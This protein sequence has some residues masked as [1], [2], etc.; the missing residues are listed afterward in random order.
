MERIFA[1][2]DE[3]WE[4]LSKE[5]E[6]LEKKFLL[7]L[8]DFLAGKEKHPSYLITGVF[9][10][11]K[12]VFLY[13]LLKKCIEKG[14]LPIF[15]I[16]VDLFENIDVKNYGEVKEKINKVIECLKQCFKS[17][18]LS[19]YEKYI[20]SMPD[21]SKKKL[22]EYYNRNLDKIRYFDKVV[23]LIDELEDAYRILEKKAGA[24]PLRTWLEDRTYLKILALTPTGIYDLGGADESRLIKET[25][26]AVSIEYI[27]EKF[28][29]NAGKANALW[30]LSRGVPRHILQ[31][32]QKLRGV[33]LEFDPYRIKEILESLE[34]I[35]KRPS[36]VPAVQI[37]VLSDFSKIKNLIDIS[38]HDIDETYEGFIISRNLDEGALANVF[39]DVFSL[40]SEKE[41]EIALLMAHY[42]KI[43]AMTLS[44]EDYQMYLDINELKDF[45]EL[46]LDIM[47]EKEHKKRIVQENIS[48]ILYIAKELEESAIRKLEREL[49]KFAREDRGL[50]YDE[51]IRKRLP[52]SISEIRNLFP[53]PSANPITVSDPQRI[54][55]KFEGQGKPICIEE[56]SEEFTVFFFASLRDLDRYAR[57]DEFLSH[58]LPEGKSALILL[59]DDV[60]EKPLEDIKD[61][62]DL[63]EWLKKNGKISIV[64]LSPQLKLFLLSLPSESAEI[65]YRLSYLIKELE[66]KGDFWQKR[67]IEIYY[68]ALQDLIQNNRPKPRYFFREKGTP[69]GLTDV[70][71]VSQLKQENIAVA[72]LALAFYNI[73]ASD[74]NN[75]M[76]I[77]RLFKTSR[78]RG[79]LADL[80]VG[81]G[82]PT[83]ADDL[84]PR[85]DKT[86]VIIDAPS[87]ED[88]KNFW[89]KEEQN[90]LETLARLS[91]LAVFKKLSHDENYKRVLEAFWRAKRNEFDV[92][93]RS[94]SDI[95]RRLEDVI[96]KLNKILG[97]IKSWKKELKLNL[98]LEKKE[99]IIRDDILNSLKRLL[100]LSFNTKLAKYI[101]FLYLKSTCEKIEGT[102]NELYFDITG[103][104]DRI[105]KLKENIN[106]IISKL[107]SKRSL[108]QF[109]SDK[110]TFEDI[111]HKLNSLIEINDDLDLSALKQK[112]Q[113]FSEF[114]VTLHAKIE[115]LENRLNKFRELL[116][117]FGVT[118]GK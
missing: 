94:I 67:K 99:N 101:Y 47:L 32:L 33:S 6:Q 34:P 107:S 60:S 10:Q 20:K 5:H 109:I 74:K 48:R 113:G 54:R 71:G 66:K 29:L 83:L 53:Q 46:V 84:L 81:G 14:M 13:H 75:L 64:K 4:P 79:A 38:P 95:R 59:P 36:K 92:T 44:D 102:I 58:V 91:D 52:F 118:N 24:D 3:T 55:D 23:L 103:V 112:I 76:E 21:S 45:M 82:L 57:T 56:V 110:L 37:G 19:E 26:P 12:T 72:G 73:S 61:S 68:K 28:Q 9:G 8:N 80:K 105:K 88:L 78:P 63:L 86:G 25:I 30:W 1:D 11:G 31:N 90:E 41:R 115:E 104:D 89:T 108:L 2:I 43:V 7:I 93:D 117:K 111:K 51:K 39:K 27:R 65:P 40:Y 100:E 116:F 62:K 35:G 50:K 16:A 15:V 97:I 114:I 69:K 106:T 77:R 17:R 70:W 42:F 49:W 85:K 87:V 22:L 98:I 18:S 96:K